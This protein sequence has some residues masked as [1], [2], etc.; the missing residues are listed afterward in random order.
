MRNNNSLKGFTLVE[1]IVV[2]AIIT[3]VL[4]LGGTII[5]ST[6]NIYNKNLDI[7]LAKQ[8]GDTVLNHIEDELSYSTS[9]N[10]S[11]DTEDYIS[12]NRYAFKVENGKLLRY[13]LNSLDFTDLYGEE[14]YNNNSI[15]IEVSKLRLPL[16][17]LTVTVFN[18]EKDIYTNQT[19]VKLLNWELYPTE[20]LFANEE[21]DI[22]NYI[23]SY[24][25]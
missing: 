7:N 24:N 2:L 14:F 23:I 3:L 22:S 16:I 19:T 18:Q 1:V 10:T 4:G 8:V 20:F 5:L 12:T 21:I 9:I 11:I 17:L 13:D 25:R 15:R 6:G